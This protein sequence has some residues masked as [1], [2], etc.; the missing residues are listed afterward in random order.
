MIDAIVTL[1]GKQGYA[2][3]TVTD[4]IELSAASRRTFYQHFSDRQDCL[5][6]A[7]EELTVTWV[8]ACA[9]AVERAKQRDEPAVDAFVSQ[10][11]VLTVGDPSALRLLL[12][13][14]RGA[15]DPGLAHHR[16]VLEG[17]GLALGK[18]LDGRRARR[19][20][21]GSSS[22]RTEP[23]VAQ[24]LAGA[25]LQ[26]SYVRAFRGARVGSPRRGEL[27]DLVPDVAEWARACGTAPTP[28][29]IVA[30]YPPPAG[31]RA[32][33]TLSPHMDAKRRRALA[34][35]ERTLSRSFVVHNQRERI[36]D[37]I[38]NLSAAKGYAAVSIPTLVSEANVSVQALYEHFVDKEDSLL[39]AY[40]LGHRKALALTE[41][42]Y[43]AHPRWRDGVPAAVATVL[44]FL[45]SEP[46]F[47]HVALID[48]PAASGRL[49][50]IANHGTAAYVE[51]LKPEPNLRRHGPTISTEASTYAI[52]ALCRLYLLDHKA[53]EMSALL[54]VAT[55]L[56]LGPHTLP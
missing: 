27:M 31:G 14:I 52:Q 48:M 41:K 17:L 10:L 28:K 26:V 39:V 53:Q 34:H 44:N 5:L 12:T 45:A 7:A 42:A 25:I 15:G 37:A 56:A 4:V 38:A 3:T 9:S 13:D 22:T 43:E 23:L 19:G 51:L 16:R 29:L 50:G 2:A 54:D 20:A 8:A 55:H 32:P 40:Q 6:R 30:G 46:S 1:V 49:A 24:A 18:A 36:L 21:S 47:A 33:G 11:F 35:S